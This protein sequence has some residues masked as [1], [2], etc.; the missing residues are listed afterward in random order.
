MNQKQAGRGA[1][2]V[3][4]V[5]SG[6]GLSIAEALGDA[7]YQVFGSVRKDA[8]AD[9]VTVRSVGRVIPVVFDV[10]DAQAVRDGVARI[11]SSVGAAGLQ[12]LVNNAGVSI[13]G[14][15]MHQ[16]MEE[17][18]STFDVN[19]FGLLEVTRACLPLLGATEAPRA[20]PGRI[21]NIGS[22]QGAFS[23]PFLGA[24]AASKQ[25]LEALSQALRR[26]LLP[27]GIEVSTIEPSFV[28]TGLFDKAA[29]LERTHPYRFTAYAEGWDRFNATL[30]KEEAGAPSP[31][32]VVAAVLHAIQSSSP[33][34]RYPLHPMWYVG[35]CLPDRW[36]DRLIL[37]ATG[38]D[39]ILRR[40]EGTT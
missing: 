36:F 1:V 3:T 21:V 40:R 12:A 33:S 26:E 23:V 11:A 39:Q 16:P 13:A 14:P 20:R 27:F 9:A 28:K 18:R 17:L 38:L 22:V 24:Y 35:R 5:S 2:L 25:A 15:L 19:V 4:G 34:T 7:G 32:R 6:I 37:K 31:Q 29:A 30:R 8:D 10:T